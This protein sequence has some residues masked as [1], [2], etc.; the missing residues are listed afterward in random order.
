MSCDQLLSAVVSKRLRHKGQPEFTKQVL[1]ASKLPYGD[2][3]WVI[4]RRASRVAVCATVAAALVTHFATRQE[5]EVDIL[6]G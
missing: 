5:T 4:G 1:S 3:S 2:G 6:I